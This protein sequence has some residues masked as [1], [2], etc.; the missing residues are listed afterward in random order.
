MKIVNLNNFQS[1]ISFYKF[2]NKDKALIKQGIKDTIE[3]SS[4]AKEMLEVSN[5][6]NIKTGLNSTIHFEDFAAVLR[7][8]EKGYI[9]VDGKD[10]K[11]SD[12]DK[13]NLLKMDKIAEEKRLAE[14][15]KRGVAVSR[16]QSAA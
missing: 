16:Q 4:R 2:S 10:I 12:E 7:A 5:S 9:K 13:K 15:Y 3:F 1:N 14:F 11:L 6:K 8:V